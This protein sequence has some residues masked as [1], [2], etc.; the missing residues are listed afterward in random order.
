MDKNNFKDGRLSLYT[1]VAPQVFDKEAADNI[2]DT[3]A[4]IT[5]ALNAFNSGNFFVMLLL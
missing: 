5:D 1:A 4:D 3:G 2:K